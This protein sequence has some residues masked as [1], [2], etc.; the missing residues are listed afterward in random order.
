MENN[1]HRIALLE[2][3]EENQRLENVTNKRSDHSKD[4]IKSL[5][6]KNEILKKRCS[7]S[8]KMRSQLKGLKDQLENRWFYEKHPLLT[9]CIGGAL[10]FLNWRY[11]KK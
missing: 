3:Q 2:L 8:D 1:K 7:E 5:R 10:V 6:E 9:L 11:F 4:T